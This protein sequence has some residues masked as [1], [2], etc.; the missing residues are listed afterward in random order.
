MIIKYSKQDIAK[1]KSKELLKDWKFN[2]PNLISDHLYDILIKRQELNT[3]CF[4]ELF[5]GAHFCAKDY[6]V[7]Y[8]PWL[9]NCLFQDSVKLRESRKEFIKIMSKAI[10]PQEFNTFLEELKKR[11]LKKGQPDLFVYKDN[12]Y[13]F[14]EV[15]READKITKEQKEFIKIARQFGIKVEIAELIINLDSINKSKFRK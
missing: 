2:Y 5:T 6:K 3:Y 7:L 12:E 14:A 4:G 10:G 8:E 1:W 13:F 9:E 11:K 15:K